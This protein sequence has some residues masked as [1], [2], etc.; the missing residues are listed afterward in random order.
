[1][2]VNLA[3]IDKKNLSGDLTYGESDYVFFYPPA[4]AI[5][6]YMSQI[7]ILGKKIMD[8]IGRSEVNHSEIIEMIAKQYQYCAIIWLFNQV[9]NSIFMNLVNAQ[10]KL[11]WYNGISHVDLDFAAQRLQPE[12][13]VMYF[14]DIV[15]KY[16]S[17]K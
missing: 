4:S 10:L 8:S 14:Q 5:S 9:N 7:T 17:N 11:I 15:K 12:N 6:E 13:F 3:G 2:S 16:N 1:M